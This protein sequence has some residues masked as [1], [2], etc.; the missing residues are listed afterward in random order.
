[1]ETFRT[2]HKIYYC[3][4]ICTTCIPSC[5]VVTFVNDLRKVVFSATLVSSTN[6]TGCLDIIKRK[7]ESGVKHHNPN[8]RLPKAK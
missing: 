2:L 3:M 8:Q 6:K 1:M 7:D 5:P 4:F